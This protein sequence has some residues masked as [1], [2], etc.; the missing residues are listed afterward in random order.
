MYITPEDFI[1]TNSLNPVMLFFL[2][3]IACGFLKSDLEIPNSISRFLFIYLLITIGFKGGASL[4]NI[5]TFNYTISAT[6]FAGLLISFT[7]PIIGYK[8]LSCTSTLNRQ[9]IVA[10]AASYGSVSI[11]TFMA[12]TNLLHIKH[13]EYGGYMV[14]VLVLME[15]PA[16]FSGLMLAKQENH[17]M[18]KTFKAILTSSSII[19]LCGS[20]IIGLITGEEGLGQFKGFFLD[21][22]QGMLA[23]FLL[24]MGLTVKKSFNKKSLLNW[25]IISFALYM[26]LIGA[27]LGLIT[28]KTIGLDIGSGFLFITLCASASYIAVPAAMRLALPE[29]N[30]SIYMPMSLSI[31]FPFNVIFGVPLYYALAQFIL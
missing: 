1:I 21:P 10:I 11:V 29:A 17:S 28:S 20:L 5:S 25:R 16:I 23:I 18:L 19:L 24:D 26:P 31:T 6:I 12:A 30:A 27:I 13:V 22:F 7:T 14:A 4:N 9:T 2:L 3:G 15:V 8:I